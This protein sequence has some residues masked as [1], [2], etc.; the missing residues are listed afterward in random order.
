M[1]AGPALSFMFTLLGK[2]GVMTGNAAGLVPENASAWPSRAL[3][4]PQSGA[5]SDE[6]VATPRDGRGLGVT[7]G[8]LDIALLKEDQHAEH[9]DIHAF[10]SASSSP[11][12]A[13]SP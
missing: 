3:R 9:E 7:G 13:V 12:P 5:A 8:D 6:A 4:R 11:I 10:L 1:T 2:D